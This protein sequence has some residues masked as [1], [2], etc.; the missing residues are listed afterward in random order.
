MLRT[1][2]EDLNKYGGIIILY[3]VQHAWKSMCG[4]AVIPFGV[5]EMRQCLYFMLGM[6]T[7]GK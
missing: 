2:G 4:E 1:M 7:T 6:A 3:R 5:F